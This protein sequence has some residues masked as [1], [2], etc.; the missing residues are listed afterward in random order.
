M[1]ERTFTYTGVDS[2]GFYHLS[3]KDYYARYGTTLPEYNNRRG[4]ATKRLTAAI[5][6]I[7]LAFG[8]GGT[9]NNLSGGNS[10]SRPAVT[11]APTATPAPYRVLGKVPG[12]G[13]EFQDSA[14]GKYVVF[15]IA[16]YF[17]RNLLGSPVTGMTLQGNTLKQTFENGLVE[18]EKQSGD[19]RLKGGN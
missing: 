3:D 19:C 16:N 5:L 1:S 8:I 14:T 9:V 7:A 4:K 11:V 10:L 17:D 6:L 18:C 2:S 15:P 12:G 13:K